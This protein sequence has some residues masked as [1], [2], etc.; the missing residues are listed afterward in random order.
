MAVLINHGSA[1]AAEIT[2][3]ALQDLKRAI[4]SGTTSGG[5]GSVQSILPMKN[6]AAV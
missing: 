4:V 3:G 2:A 6:G 1:S 5:K